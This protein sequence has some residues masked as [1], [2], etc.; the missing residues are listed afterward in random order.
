MENI[1]KEET[2]TERYRKCLK[3]P[4]ES[5]KDYLSQESDA[6]VECTITE[7]YI[8]KQLK[9]TCYPYQK[10]W[11]LVIEKNKR[12]AFCICN[13]LKKQN[14]LFG[15][16]LARANYEV[17][18]IEID[19]V[20]KEILFKVGTNRYS[21]EVFIKKNSLTLKERKIQN[22]ENSR[23]CLTKEI[24]SDFIKESDYSFEIGKKIVEKEFLKR[25][26]CCF[27]NLDIVW[28]TYEEG[29]DSQPIFYVGEIK[30]KTKD[31]YFKINK[32]SL[33]FYKDITLHSDIHVM[34]LA[35]VSE[36]GKKND[37]VRNLMVGEDVPFYYHEL[38]E[39]DKFLEENGFVSDLGRENGKTTTKICKIPFCSFSKFLSFENFDSKEWSIKLII[40][41]MVE[42]NADL[43]HGMYA[44][45]YERHLC[46]MYSILKLV[47][48]GCDIDYESLF[49]SNDILS[50]V[51]NINGSNVLFKYLENSH[52]WNVTF[53]EQEFL[54]YEA[55]KVDFVV[56]YKKK[57]LSYTIKERDGL[58]YPQISCNDKELATMEG[59]LP[60]GEFESKKHLY[61]KNYKFTQKGCNWVES[62]EKGEIGKEE[63]L[64]YFELFVPKGKN[65]D[66]KYFVL[67]RTKEKNFLYPTTNLS[68]TNSFL[69][70]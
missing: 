51:L 68:F 7:N 21:A 2:L 49:E 3:T 45:E 20:S 10:D 43:F 44:H 5:I 50:N 30:H 56:L 29:F 65:E 36:K 63:L 23:S 19:E 46:R 39:S 61:P 25:C 60:F 12:Y 47:E 38:S 62:F 1:L 66:T 58:R 11:W 48:M 55:K 57:D 41:E 34:F 27:I 28:M 4:Y 22:Y 33:G 16:E 32:G 53:S 6:L 24:V 52:S 64:E 15:I 42:Q 67:Y 13:Q 17:V 59:W 37:L 54:R 9:K 40:N 35:Y 69:L 8:E 31:A 14:L 70:R 26:F 18:Y